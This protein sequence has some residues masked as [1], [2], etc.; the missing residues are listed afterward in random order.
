MLYNKELKSNLNKFNT[1]ISALCCLNN[2]SVHKIV[3]RKWQGLIYELAIF[4]MCTIST[5]GFEAISFSNVIPD[6]LQL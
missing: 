3:E 1:C 2:N 4:D 5:E 6:L